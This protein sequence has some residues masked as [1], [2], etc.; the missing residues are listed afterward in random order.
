MIDNDHRVFHAEGNIRSDFIKTVSELRDK[1]V[2]V[3]QDEITELTLQMGNKK[4]T[5]VKAVAP[6]SVDTTEKKG[7]QTAP[8]E[9][10]SKWITSDGRPVKDNEIDS[11]IG[12]LTDY[13]C[14]E[15]IE[16][17]TNQD[18]TSPVYTATLKGTKEYSISFYA[19]Q[20][21]QY[22]A[23]TSESEYPF[24]VS[25][26]KADKIMKDLDSLLESG[27]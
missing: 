15:F 23:V 16:D 20:D 17:K 14:D 25:E 13:R 22:P 27:Q 4:M 19:K 11:I 5:I 9:T 18:F 1:K 26:W 8:E 7:E 2:M 24:M 3:I 6:V 10:D 12:S 21:E